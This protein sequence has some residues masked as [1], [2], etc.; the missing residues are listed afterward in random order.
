MHSTTPMADKWPFQVNA[1]RIRTEFSCLRTVFCSL[2]CMSEPIEGG[3]YHIYGR[4]YGRGEITAHATTRQESLHPRKRAI[5]GLHNV[6]PRSP[7]DVHVNEPRNQNVAREVRHAAVG[8]N[9]TMSP[10]SD[11]QDGSIL[12]QQ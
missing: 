8:G 1:K 5:V 9:F 10:R 7:M 6:V 11:F 4:R 3:Q 2:H 12:H